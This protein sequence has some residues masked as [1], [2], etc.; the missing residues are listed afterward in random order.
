MNKLNRKLQ[1]RIKSHIK[2]G[3][4][5][6]DDQDYDR[7][8]ELFMTA[9]DLLPAPKDS[10]DEGIQLLAGIGDVLFMQGNAQEAYEYFSEAQK[11]PGG[12]ENPFIWLRL[13]QC[14]YDMRG[15]KEAI[16]DALMSAY[17]LD[18]FEIFSDEDSKYLEFLKK[19]V[20][21][22]EG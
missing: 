8:L 9:Y 3:E 5:F 18:G 15:R 12:V 7:A 11:Y 21:L 1:T 13:G 16:L 4:N 22:Y 6:F 20:R 19:H 14:L 17:L 10:W 2:K